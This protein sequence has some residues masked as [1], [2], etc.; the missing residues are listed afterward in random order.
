MPLRTSLRTRLRATRRAVLRRRRPLAALAAGVAVAA[1]V[2][3]V[4]APPP[5]RVELLTA[6]H[7]LP[8][9][10]VVGHDDVVRVG[11]APGTAPEGLAGHPVGRT[12]ATAV[13]RGEPLTDV[14]LV[15]PT[16]SDAALS[17]DGRL[18]TPV[19]LPD[20]GMAGLLAVG[21]RIDLVATDPQTG[22]AETVAAGVPVLAMPRAAPQADTPG[23]LVVVGVL[24]GEVTTVTSAAVGSFLTYAFSR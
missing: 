19:R 7:D 20:A 14:R 4:A 22:T 17:A 6:A 13:R 9:G 5:T 15:A 8:A 10:S 3:T 11:F 2:H 16:L 24:P 21:D 1:V 18:A 12:V 23:A